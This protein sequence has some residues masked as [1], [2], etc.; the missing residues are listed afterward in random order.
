MTGSAARIAVS[1]EALLPKPWRHE[2]SPTELVV[3]VQESIAKHALFPS[4]E[5]RA[6]RVSQ[7][8]VFVAH[9]APRHAAREGVELAA[10]FLFAFFLLNDHWQAMQ[11]LLAGDANANAGT[12]FVRDWLQR[13]RDGFGHRSERFTRAFDM[14]LKSLQH[15]QRY[16][17][18]L[19][20]SF[21][22]YVDKDQGRYQWVATAPYIELWELTLGIELSPSAR[23]LA[24]ELK[25]LSVELTYIANDIGSLARDEARKNYV[26]LLAKRDGLADLNDALRAAV[27]VYERKATALAQRRDA[28]AKSDAALP[29]YAE[30]TCNIADGNLR[31]TTL[32]AY[33]GS[34]GRYSPQVRDCLAQLP[35]VSSE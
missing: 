14:Y 12:R 4:E 10:E 28:L 23:V 26:T 31:A 32:L 6:K 18:G 2:L 20:P 29:R 35:L 7:I 9:C 3:F 21:E 24:E 1:L 25:Q 8:R 15:E 13:V 33:A 17:T 11:G 22:E 34:S 30:L 5:T 16:A 19:A 27:S